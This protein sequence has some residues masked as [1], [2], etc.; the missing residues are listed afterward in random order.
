MDFMTMSKAV[1]ECKGDLSALTSQGTKEKQFLDQ[2]A[3]VK[4][5]NQLSLQAPMQYKL[6]NVEISADSHYSN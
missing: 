2:G 3:F 1:A 6:V 5:R 4:L